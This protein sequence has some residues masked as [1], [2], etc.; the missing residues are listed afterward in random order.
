MR[1]PGQPRS[2]SN[3]RN[4]GTNLADPGG[5]HN[6][7]RELCI[8]ERVMLEGFADCEFTSRA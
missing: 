6:R 4:D 5:C 3:V 2:A 1:N 7:T 8:K